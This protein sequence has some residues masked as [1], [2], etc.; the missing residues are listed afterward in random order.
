M[1]SVEQTLKA[2]AAQGHSRTSACK[3]IGWTW[4]TFRT[5]AADY[6]SISWR[7]PGHHMIKESAICTAS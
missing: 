2:L 5:V 4:H 1:Q 3:S 6:P 7:L